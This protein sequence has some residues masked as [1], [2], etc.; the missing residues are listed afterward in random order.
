MNKPDLTKP[1]RQELRGFLVI[2]VFEVLKILRVF[3]PVFI[4]IFTQKKILPTGLTIPMVVGLILL[5]LLIHSILFYLNFY[6][7][8]EENQFILKK[9]YLRKKV[10]SIPLDRIQSVN[11]KQNILQQALNVYSLEVDTAG[12][13]GKELKIYSLSGSYADHL[14]QFL[15]TYKENKIEDKSELDSNIDEDEEIL[16]LSPSDLL[17]IGISQNHL[18]TGLFI[19]AFGSQIV[20][21]IQ[22]LFKKQTDAYSD[23]VQN[24]LSNSGV[25]FF[26]GL[27]LFFLVASIFATLLITV[28]KYYDYKL[29]KHQKSYRITAG[30]IN[31]RK[32]LLPFTKVQQLN[33][34]TGPIKKLFGIFRIS[35]KQAVSKQTRQKQI[36]DAPGCLK[37]HIE[38]V[39]DEIFNGDLPDHS[40]KIYV[41][42]RYF[43]R[44]WLIGGWIPAFI[45][46]ALYIYDPMWLI[47]GGSWLTL[48][49]LY[50]RMAVRKRYFQFNK[51]Q[52]IVGKGA[53]NTVWQQAASFKTQSVD[54]RQ[55]FIQKRK[56]LASLRVYNAS[57]HMDIPYIPEDMANRLMNYLLY[58]IETSNKEWM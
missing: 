17:R 33:W 45:P 9:G 41:H 21:Q 36:V 57:G 4:I 55:S 34:E 32:V 31:K 6:F 5:L 54:F 10:L 15:Q 42:R 51:T 2:F 29:V 49:A 40:K 12:S 53:I 3:W 27:A 58:H 7:Y 46:I 24:I 26:T 43:I 25:L 14:T 23:S 11:T 30:L 52:L 56:G 39:R 48:S 37:Q 28:I 50:C 8:V 19:V 20:G 22:D 1:T 44:L 18:R 16:T 13:A 38:S 47:A 35:F